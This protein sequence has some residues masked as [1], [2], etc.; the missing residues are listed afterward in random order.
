V[1]LATNRV[2]RDDLARALDGRVPQLFTIGDALAARMF[3][4]ATFEGQMFARL[5]GEPGGGANVADVW[6]APDPPGTLNGA[7]P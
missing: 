4:A 3:A 2:P 7:A 6:F 1:V 5:I